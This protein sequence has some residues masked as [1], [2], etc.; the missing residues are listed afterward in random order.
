MSVTLEFGNEIL[1][2]RY[3]PHLAIKRMHHEFKA[4]FQRVL[5]RLINNDLHTVTA[6]SQCN[7]F[8]GPNPISKE[9]TYEVLQ[10][11][12]HVVIQ[13]RIPFSPV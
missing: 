11:T 4:G 8:S 3:T 5:L 7:L 1:Q 2:E 6:S 13:P 10:S 12:F 9:M